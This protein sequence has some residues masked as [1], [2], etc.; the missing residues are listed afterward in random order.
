[1][2][3]RTVDKYEADNEYIRRRLDE[4]SAVV[5]EIRGELKS[6]KQQVVLIATLVASLITAVINIVV[7]R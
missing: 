3:R 1:V 6:W 5:Y 7:G 2:S 4:I